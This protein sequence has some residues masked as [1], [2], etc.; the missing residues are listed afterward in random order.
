MVTVYKEQT[1]VRTAI[2]H[3]AADR[4]YLR[5]WLSEVVPT[6][7][8][9]PMASDM[10]AKLERLNL[11][12]H[13]VVVH[14]PDVPLLVLAAAGTG[15]TEALTMRIAHLVREFG[16]PPDD[17]L[18]VTFSNRAAR[19]MRER[20]A[21]LCDIRSED[22][23]SIST[24]HALCVRILRMHPSFACGFVILDTK[25]SLA[26]LHDV[27]K[28]VIPGYDKVKPQAVYGQLNRWR[29]DG[30]DPERVP[31]PAQQSS[32]DDIPPTAELV[33]YRAFRPYREACSEAKAVDFAD[34]L[35]HAVRL[36]NTDLAFLERLRSRW[37]HVLVDEF[38]VKIDC[39]ATI[40]S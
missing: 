24:F 2:Y 8:T 38:Q 23:R 19:E 30:L 29:N 22:M 39:D 37:T 25:D 3:K 1:G 35:C 7:T 28:D 5:V 26:V 11:E 36:C 18:A 40:S 33:A 12:Q 9:S 4:A 16:V 10:Q 27:C 32:D 13:A 20:A 17:I 15:K 14:P 6:A 34:L 21:R 31:P